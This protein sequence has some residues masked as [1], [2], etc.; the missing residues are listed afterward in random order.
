M[1]E[2]DFNGGLIAWIMGMPFIILIFISDRNLKIEKINQ[3]N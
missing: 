3:I 2:T 1:E